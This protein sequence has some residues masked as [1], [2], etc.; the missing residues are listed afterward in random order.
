[1]KV[2]SLVIG[3]GYTSQRDLCR[4]KEVIAIDIDAT[5]VKKA[6]K[7][8]QNTYYIVCD[9][10]FLPFRPCFFVDV[11]CTDVLEH[12]M[13]YEKVV[14][15][16]AEL[17][18]NLV[19][20]RF[21]TEAREKLL[22]KTSRVYREQHWG[23]IHVSIVQPAK[24]IEILKNFEYSAHKDFTSATSTL[25]RLVMQILLEAVKCDYR[26]PEIGL[27]SFPEERSLWKLIVCASRLFGMLGNITFLLYKLSRIETLHDSYIIIG[28]Y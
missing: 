18:A 1:M 13:T 20:L 10:L 25:T 17:K 19:Y 28:T 26:I 12:I 23:K 8:D 15:N 21:P 22:I 11:I 6:K 7:L 24:V 14:G 16:I 4:S 2:F 3:C 5:K 27:V 9:A